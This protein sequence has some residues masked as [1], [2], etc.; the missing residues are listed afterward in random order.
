MLHSSRSRSRGFFAGVVGVLALFLSLLV[1]APA[2]ALADTGTGGVFV[3]A[4]GRVLDTKYN[5]GGYNTPMPGG[6]WRTVKVAGNAGIPDDGSVGAVAVTAVILDTTYGQLRGRPNADTATTLMSIYAGGG[7]T[8]TSNSSIVA[9]NGDGTLQVMTST[10]A[11]L[12]LDVQGYYTSSDDGT[13]AG[14]FVPVAGTRIVDTRS[15]TGL[16]KAVVA[17]GDTKTIQVTGTAGVPAGASGVVVTMIAVN[18]E[19]KIG[20]LTPFAYGAAQPKNSFQYQESQ[21]TAMSAQVAL[22][23]NGKLSINNSGSSTDLVVDVQGYF[24]AAGKGGAMFTPAAGR[25]YDTRTG[26][27]TALGTNA[28][29]S[30]QIAGVAGVPVMGSGITAVVI[31]LTAVHSDDSE[32]RAIVWADGTARPTVT[33]MDYVAGS[34]RSNT[35]TVPLG[36]NGKI[37]LYN[38]GTPTEYV[39]DVQGWYVNPAAPTISCPSNYTAGSWINSLPQLDITCTVSAPA[40]SSTDDMLF[41]SVNEDPVLVTALN[42]TG[43]TKAA[44]S[45]A[46]TTGWKD[47]TASTLTASDDGESTEL[48]FG[49]NESK[50]SATLAAVQNASPDSFTDIDTT[51]LMGANGLA[52]QSV[53]D[54]PSTA[55]KTSQGDLELQSDSSLLTAGL[56]FPNSQ[57]GLTEAPGVVSYDNGNG[58]TTVP[59]LHTDG[60]VQVATVISSATAP[61]SFAYPIS[62]P[63]GGSLSID[64]SSGA[65]LVKDSTGLLLASMDTPW[66]RDA[67]GQDVPTHFEVQGDSI[68]QKVEHQGSGVA[69]PVVAD[70]SIWKILAASAQCA[71]EIAAIALAGAKALKILSKVD[72]IVKASEAALK[73]YKKLGGKADKFVKVLKKYIKK[74]SSLSK[75]QIK[76][77]EIIIVAVG[78]LIFTALGLPTCFDLIRG[79]I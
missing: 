41:V 70:P 60:T 26:S 42:E 46:A 74:K 49:L 35:V 59:L 57:T 15:G 8:S 25:A 65:A 75:D 22:S 43:I 51:A 78:N 73:A 4:S 77:I 63:Q 45:V 47:I 40:A 56:P 16:P 67:N 10:D 76:A 30:I 38:N 55:P 14:G 11:R 2:Q 32:G 68:V 19:A 66:A 79:K 3:P 27:N 31:T 72:R 69:Y 17:S 52:M 36:A 34:T 24:T 1:A 9:L 18:K 20:T 5:T 39:I 61:Q 23:S 7:A 44:F 21:D 62:L 54:D 33:S 13:A 6:A 53:G 64:P 71:V 48:A 50:P 58:S 28:T 37:S 12:V 29:R